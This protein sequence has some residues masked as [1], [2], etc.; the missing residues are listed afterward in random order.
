MFSYPKGSGIVGNNDHLRPMYH[1]TKDTAERAELAYGK[2][3]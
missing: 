1:K 3:V 2:I